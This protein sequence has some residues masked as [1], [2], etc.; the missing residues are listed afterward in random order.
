MCT[1]SCRANVNGL[2]ASVAN[3]GREYSYSHS[4]HER[5]PTIDIKIS[6]KKQMLSPIDSTKNNKDRL[7]DTL[8]TYENKLG[9]DHEN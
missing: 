2:L 1:A 5:A 9:R 7:L 6:D 4:E 8:H 3:T